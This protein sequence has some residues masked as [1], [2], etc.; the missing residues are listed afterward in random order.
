MA[1]TTKSLNNF[2]AT[3]NLPFVI[4]KYDAD[5]SRRSNCILIHSPIFPSTVADIFSE[6]L[7]WRN[8]GGRWNFLR[9]V[10]RFKWATLWP[11]SGGT[12]VADTSCLVPS[13]H[14]A[15]WCRSLAAGQG[16]RG[17]WITSLNTTRQ[18]Y[19]YV[20]LAFIGEQER[21]VGNPLMDFS[22]PEQEQKTLREVCVETRVK[23]CSS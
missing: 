9:V 18:C 4:I 2:L 15:G 12:S 1:A 16:R 13:G 6:Q 22:A 23:S 14:S 5:E 19:T 11:G 7:R 20:Y 21:I 3:T 10:G 17:K 8:I